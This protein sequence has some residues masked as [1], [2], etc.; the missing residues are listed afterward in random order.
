MNSNNI[1]SL[2]KG[3]W[4]RA[5]TICISMMQ[6]ANEK[7]SAERC[8]A[9]ISSVEMSE[10]GITILT[11]NAFA[12]ETLAKQYD[13]DIKKAFVLAGADP[14]TKIA[15][16]FDESSKPSI[17]IPKVHTQTQAASFSEAEQLKK[18]ASSLRPCL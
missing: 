10:D 6:G 15:Y 9:M 2:H 14:D 8:F 11:S 17:V 13:D 4:E 12:C 7:G 1:E 18:G 16:K 3:L 5:R